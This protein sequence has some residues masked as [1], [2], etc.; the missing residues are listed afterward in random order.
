M[1]AGPDRRLY[2]AT[3]EDRRVNILD[4]ATGATLAPLVLPEETKVIAIEIAGEK[5]FI[6]E[7]FEN[8]PEPQLWRYDM[9]AAEPVLEHS[10]PQVFYAHN[11]EAASD[12]SFLTTFINM[13]LTQI[14]GQTLAPIRTIFEPN[15]FIGSTT[16]A[17]DS[18]KFDVLAG[19][20]SENR[21]FF[22]IEPSSGE[23]VITGIVDLTDN[24]YPGIG[25]KIVALPNGGVAV[26]FHTSV[27]FYHSTQYA[28]AVPVVLKTHCA[29]GPVYD[30]FS[31]VNSGWPSAILESIVIGY[32]DGE[33]TILQQD[34]DVW[35]AVS[36]GD[37]WADARGASI[38]TR[39][40]A[41][42]GLSGLVFGLNADWSHFFTFEVIPSLGR[43]V[44][45]EYTEGI[46][47]T[48][49]MTGV[50]YNIAPIG[51]WNKLTLNPIVSPD[52]VY[53]MV[54]GQIVGEVSNVPG[55][56]GLSAGSFEPDFE[57][58]FDNYVFM[59][60]NCLINS[61][62]SDNQLPGRAGEIDVAPAIS[63]PPLESFL[64][65]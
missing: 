30:D 26:V 58:R 8:N 39:L 24:P 1:A 51:D 65:E 6:G 43:W 9:S 22:G 5:M 50:P 49:L 16:I 64:G 23:K 40:P 42:D 47:W 44:V 55:R 3:Y 20:T 45:F 13:E 32:I 15:Q 11:M 48:L 37:F 46:G 56:I 17:L 63:R 38:T 28:A 34:A 2:W 52:Q 62:L 18:S 60:Q 54:N 25:E 29:G 27:Y 53:L 35:F 57:A 4:P 31:D 12:G 41:R 14:D 10:A 7:T 21:P 33:Y 36:R 61:P 19:P 59:G